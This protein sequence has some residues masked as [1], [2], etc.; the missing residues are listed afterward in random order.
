MSFKKPLLIGIAVAVLVVA[1]G[2]IIIDRY[3][4][5]KYAIFQ[6]HPE[7]FDA[8]KDETERLMSQQ[9][10]LSDTGV[11]ILYSTGGNASVD[12]FHDMV[13]LSLQ[14]KIRELDGWSDRKLSILRYSKQDGTSLIQFLFDWESA[15]GNPYHIVYCESRDVLENAYA[16]EHI[17]YVLDKLKGNWYGLALN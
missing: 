15:Y 7:L 17:K 2:N 8:I 12:R 16:K 13:S 10:G 1:A 3:Y 4:R 6:D 5:A 14:N 9:E 11:T